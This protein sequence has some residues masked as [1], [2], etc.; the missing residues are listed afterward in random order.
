MEEQLAILVSWDISL[1]LVMF[2]PRRGQRTHPEIATF[3][4]GLRP[5]MERLNSVT[6]SPGS[7]SSE[8]TFWPPPSLWLLPLIQAM[9]P[10]WVMS[11]PPRPRGSMW[12]NMANRAAWELGQPGGW[13][14]LG[15]GAAPG[16]DLG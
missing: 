6:G 7:L 14:S 5:P 15:D 16:W 9:P 13:G 1:M 12:P 3:G 4:L 2:R 8:E 10:S 11:V